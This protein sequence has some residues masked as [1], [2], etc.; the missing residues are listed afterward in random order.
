MINTIAIDDEPLALQLVN[1]YIEKTPGLKLL[2]GFDNPLD[3]IDFLA[4]KDIDLIF[5]DIQMPDLSGLEFTRSMA[6]GPKIIFTTAYEKYALEGF[7]TSFPFLNPKEYMS[8]RHHLKWLFYHQ[9]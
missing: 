3:A 2:G 5:I 1:G 8:L 9:G 6:K 4:G 7:L